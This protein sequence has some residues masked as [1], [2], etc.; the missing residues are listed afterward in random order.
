MQQADN[1]PRPLNTPDHDA[2]CRP[3]PKEAAVAATAYATK[4]KRTGR[5]SWQKNE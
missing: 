2:M 3:A 1:R 5:S 4:W